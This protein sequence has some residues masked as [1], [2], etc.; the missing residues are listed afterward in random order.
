MFSSIHYVSLDPHGILC[1]H[2]TIHPSLPPSTPPPSYYVYPRS[3]IPIPHHTLDPNRHTTVSY[4]P[5]SL[6]FVKINSNLF[7]RGE[8]T[9]THRTAPHR[10]NAHLLRVT[11]SPCLPPRTYPSVLPTREFT[12]MLLVTS[13]ISPRTKKKARREGEKERG[14][15]KT[16]RFCSFSVE[17]MKT[18]LDGTGD[19]TENRIEGTKKK[20]PA[21][22]IEPNRKIKLKIKNAPLVSYPTNTSPHHSLTHY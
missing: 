19:R 14:K 7:Q 20:R 4:P 21:R 5:P 8:L 16:L 18:Q 13:L 6:F 15:I 1:P 22:N 2:P 11:N 17:K 3:P 12:P 10:T 9:E